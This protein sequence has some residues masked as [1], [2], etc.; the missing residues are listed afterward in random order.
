MEL[1]T[2]GLGLLV[3]TC[4]KNKEVNNA[5]D[6]FVSG[7]VKWMRGWFKKSDKV[8]LIQQMEEAP[9]SPEVQAEVGNAMNE[10][11]KDDQFRMELQKWIAESKKPNPSMKNVITRKNT[12][13]GANLDISGNI[14]IG[15][16][17]AGQDHYDEKNTMKNVTI[18]GGGDFTLGD[19]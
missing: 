19:G 16:K 7:S 4:A 6:D 3:N 17:N 18:K 13:E 1:I 12:I 11:I 10:L 15:D 14:K 5:I 9:E 2:L 8:A